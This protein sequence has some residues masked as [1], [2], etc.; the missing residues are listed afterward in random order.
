MRVIT[1]MKW[2]SMIVM[3][4]MLFAACSELNPTD[5]NSAQSEN[6]IT[7]AVEKSAEEATEVDVTI[8]LTMPGSAVSKL[9]RAGFAD[10]TSVKVSVKQGSTFRVENQEFTKNGNTWEGTLA[11]M[12]VGIELSFIAKAYNG[13]TE[14]FNGMTVT[15]LA[16]SVTSVSITLA[17]SEGTKT[18][19]FPKVEQISRTAAGVESGNTSQINFFLSG[20]FGEALQWDILGTAG[21]F[22]PSSGTVTLEGTSA[23]LVVDFTAPTT[24]GVYTHSFRLTNT[25]GNSIKVVFNTTIIGLGDANVSLYFNPSIENLASQRVGDNI[26]L[27]A[28][29]TDDKALSNLNY[30]WTFSGDATRFANPTVNPA[31]LTGYT[32]N[33]AGMIE[34]VV[35]DADGGSSTLQYNLSKEQFPNDDVLVVDIGK[36]TIGKGGGPYTNESWASMQTKIFSTC[37]GCHGGGSPTMG[38]SWEATKY[39]EVVTAGKMSTAGIPYIAPGNPDGSYAVQKIEGAGANYG[40]S[41]MPLG[42]PNVSDANVA[43]LREWILAGANFEAKPEPAGPTTSETWT[44]MQ[45]DVFSKC[46]GCHGGGSPTMGLSW[47]ASKYDEVVTNAKVSTAGI[48][49]IAVGDVA[50]SY[51]IQK[52]EGAGPNFSGSKMPLGGSIDQATIDRVKEWIAA[53]APQ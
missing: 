50:S 13:T 19:K 31:Q 46:T 14:V 47:E 48:P 4:S 18:V 27:E 1:F 11:K 49:Y 23:K 38:L 53:G 15:T 17:T 5:K 10:V 7:A 32:T 44:T 16:A 45:T 41:R 40:G 25:Q 21:S 30:S 35:T 28:T 52:L 33:D 37:T 26:I 36:E 12:P 2:L 20:S 42:G 43:L 6:K 34:L 39:D 3:A 29:V 51:L 24:A 8:Q 22:T 9:A